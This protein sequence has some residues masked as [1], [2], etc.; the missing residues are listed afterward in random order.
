MGCR[1]DTG[2]GSA[3]D[4]QEQTGSIVR[5]GLRMPPKREHSPPEGIRRSSGREDWYAQGASV[6][7]HTSARDHCI[8]HTRE[9]HLGLK[10]L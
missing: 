7:L 10:K 4:L 5:H 8:A 6:S 2:A 1:Q 9:D 3:V